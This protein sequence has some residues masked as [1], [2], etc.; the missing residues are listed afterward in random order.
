MHDPVAAQKFLKNFLKETEKQKEAKSKEI[1]KELG[2]RD[3]PY[4]L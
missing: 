2:S 4:A 1:K 3:L